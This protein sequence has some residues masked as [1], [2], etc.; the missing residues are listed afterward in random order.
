LTHK[1][2]LLLASASPR[3]RELL[4]LLGVPLRVYH[5][6]IDESRLDSEAPSSYVARMA[7]EK[8]RA[9]AA[10]ARGLPSLGADTVVLLDDDIL[11]KP[12]NRED[13]RRMLRRLA[14]R[15]HEV[16]TAV[17][18]L[19]PEGRLEERMNRSTVSF[20]HMTESWIDAYCRLDEPMDKAGSYAIQGLAAQWVRRIEGSYSSVMGL[21]LFETAELLR[22]AGLELTGVGA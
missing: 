22:S 19:H 17:A 13:A 6:D 5:A 21:P 11:L 12:V 10:E 7:R 15:D 1:P 20:G 4:A 18:L 2:R 14:G 16:L 9:G 8:A 3:R